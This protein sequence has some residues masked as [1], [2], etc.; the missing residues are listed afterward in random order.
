M[1]MSFEERATLARALSRN[2]ELRALLE[3]SQED[4]K[5]PLLILKPEFVTLLLLSEEY[6]NLF[7]DVDLLDVYLRYQES[8]ESG[9]LTAALAPII[10][11]APPGYRRALQV[12][13]GE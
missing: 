9:D 11:A 13:L 7:A 5:N 4:I 10:E 3:S 1:K 6:P 12:L 2:P 8:L